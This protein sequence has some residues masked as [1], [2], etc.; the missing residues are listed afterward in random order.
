MAD[1]LF[2]LFDGNDANLS[3]GDRA[4][5]RR[6]LERVP[7]LVLAN[8]LTPV[9]HSEP[10][11]FTA[12]GSGPP[13]ALEIDFRDEAALKAA[14]AGNDL[15]PLVS[16]PSLGGLRSSHQA[17]TRREFAVSDPA[18]RVGPG[19]P[20]CTFLV[21]Y[22]GRTDDLPAWLDHYDANHPP[23]MVRFPGIRAVSTFRPAAQWDS[24]LPFARGTAMQRNKVVFDSV[25]ALVDALASP[26]MAEM[27]ADAATFPP[28]AP[29][30]VHHAMN[31]QVIRPL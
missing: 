16:L 27:R 2:I 26:V 7:G 11:P 31:T 14:L 29:R 24:A 19:E 9:G 3:D 5:V 21:Q 22:L 8:V 18:L 1:T 20:F 6:T 10:H 4:T 23:I 25:R 12:D 15:A 13:L 28:Y 30:A 17:M